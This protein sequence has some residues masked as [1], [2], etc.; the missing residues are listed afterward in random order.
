MSREDGGVQIKVSKIIQTRDHHH[1]LT[2]HIWLFRYFQQSIEHITRS[3]VV[4]KA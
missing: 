1:F 3:I 4:K 2:T